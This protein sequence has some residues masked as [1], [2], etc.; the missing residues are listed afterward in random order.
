MAQAAESAVERL[1]SEI[2]D[3]TIV[4]GSRLRETELSSQLGVSRTPVREALRLLAAEG[5]VE[6]LPNRG[7][8]VVEWSAQDIEEM[9][10]LRVMLESHAAARAAERI[11][12]EAL[13]RLTELCTRMEQDLERHGDASSDVLGRLNSEFHDGIIRAAGS[14]RLFSLIQTVVHTPLVMRTFHRYSLAERRRS[15]T[16]HREL[17]EA[18][19]ARDARW[20]ST[21]MQAHI[22]AA[23]SVLVTPQQVRVEPEERPG[24]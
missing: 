23:R 8:R 19:A 6:V 21:V 14:Q 11:E 24:A 1:R 7:A 15:M 18:F 20:A 5:L 10:D 13:A 3:G 12:P 17:T 22:L 9:Y 16:H 4:Q 2:L